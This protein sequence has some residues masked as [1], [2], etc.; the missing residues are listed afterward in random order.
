MPERTSPVLPAQNSTATHGIASAERTEIE[1]R[2]ASWGRCDSQMRSLV[3][4]VI[5]N[6]TAKFKK[7]NRTFAAGT[8]AAGRAAWALSGSQL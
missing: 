1:S 3:A 7:G 4:V 6:R 2:D 5:S 8:Q